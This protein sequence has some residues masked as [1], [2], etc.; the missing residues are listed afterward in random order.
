MKSKNPANR[1]VRKRAVASRL[2]RSGEDGRRVILDFVQ[3]RI[4]AFNRRAGRW[5]AG[6]QG[7][8]R[9]HVDPRGY[10]HPDREAS[11]EGAKGQFR[12]AVLEHEPR[13]LAAIGEFGGSVFSASMK[14]SISSPTIPM[15]CFW[16]LSRGAYAGLTPSAGE[17]VK[18]R[19]DSLRPASGIR[20]PGSVARP[21]PGSARQQAGRRRGE[22]PRAGASVEKERAGSAGEHVLDAAGRFV[23]GGPDDFARPVRQRGMQ[24]LDSTPVVPGKAQPRGPHPNRKRPA[25]RRRRPRPPAAMQLEP[26][27]RRRTTGQ[28][29]NLRRRDRR[30]RSPSGDTW[31]IFRR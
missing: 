6:P 5:R 9:L 3:C 11:T 7:S 24:G 31:S 1:R 12:G 13:A 19:G 26:A 30:R 8:N 16:N 4:E 22:P 28:A 10:R 15:E 14:P 18:S 21:A 25:I 20:P 17:R 23:A 29:A 27:G 2:A